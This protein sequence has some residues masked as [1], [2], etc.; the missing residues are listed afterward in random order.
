MPTGER[1]RLC[2][3]C[4][5]SSREH[6]R[7]WTILCVSVWLAYGH[8]PANLRWPRRPPRCSLVMHL[9]PATRRITTH[10]LHIWWI[11]S[12]VL[13]SSRFSGT[14]KCH[15]CHQSRVPTLRRPWFN[16]NQEKVYDFTVFSSV[17]WL[18]GYPDDGSEFNREKGFFMNS[19]LNK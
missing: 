18:I 4:G 7:R 9:T 16:K 12:L 11:S 10:L 6:L 19:T 2:W 17:Y 13:I 8:Q 1:C 3:A 15:N 14:S 5:N